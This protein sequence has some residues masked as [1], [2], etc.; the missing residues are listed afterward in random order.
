MA[1]AVSGKRKGKDPSYSYSSTFYLIAF[2][3]K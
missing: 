3:V 2:I 1:L